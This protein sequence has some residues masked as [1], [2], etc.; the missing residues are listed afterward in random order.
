MKTVSTILD[1][2]AVVIH[3]FE[4]TEGI[5]YHSH[6]FELKKTTNNRKAK[7]YTHVSLD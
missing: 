6:F 7:T 4:R 5:I 3:N 2:P 1:K